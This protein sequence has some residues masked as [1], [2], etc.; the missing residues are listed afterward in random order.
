[1][2]CA[3]EW[4]QIRLSSQSPPKLQWCSARVQNAYMLPGL[5]VSFEITVTLEFISKVTGWRASSKPKSTEDPSSC[6]FTNFRKDEKPVLEIIVERTVAFQPHRRASTGK[7]V[8]SLSCGRTRD[9]L[10]PAL[11]E[12]AGGCSPPLWVKDRVA[13]NCKGLLLLAFVTFN[14]RFR[15]GHNSRGGGEQSI[16]ILQCNKRRKGPAS[17]RL[18]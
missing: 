18:D 9:F 12:I 10:C 4:R 14:K 17:R 16:S 2:R 8:P 5:A 1:M 3:E 11:W 13:I 7:Q 6:F 15:T